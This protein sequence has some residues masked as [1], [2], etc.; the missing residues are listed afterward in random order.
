[1]RCPA[2]SQRMQPDSSGE[3]PVCRFP[4]AEVDLNVR[5]I[6]QVTGA[7][8]LSTLAY[9][10]VVY[11]V[12]TTTDIRAV[13]WGDMIFYALAAACVPVAIGMFAVKNV[14]VKAAFC[15]VPAIFGLFAFL[16]SGNIA[17]FVAL[18]GVALVLFAIMAPQVVSHVNEI[19]AEAVEQWRSREQKRAF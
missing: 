12:S 9:A 8:F 1:M 4:A 3:C 19:R 7:I 16:I 6:Y 17:R 11:F 13:V 14:I 10:L 15:E 5:R 2:C 18:L